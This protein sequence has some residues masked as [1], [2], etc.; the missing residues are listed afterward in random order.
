MIYMNGFGGMCFLARPVSLWTAHNDDHRMWV[1]P[2]ITQR[3]GLGGPDENVVRTYDDQQAWA[4]KVPPHYNLPRPFPGMLRP[5]GGEHR[6]ISRPV[7][8]EGN[9]QV[10]PLRTGRATR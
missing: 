5:K 8:R 6:E 1:K 4:P 3:I 2:E 10:N 7:G 9:F